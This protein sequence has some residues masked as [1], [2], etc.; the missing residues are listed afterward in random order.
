[1]KILHVHEIMDFA[2]YRTP[3]PVIYH[4]IDFHKTELGPLKNGNLTCL[5]SFYFSFWMHNACIR[6]FTQSDAGA[7]GEFALNAIVRLIFFWVVEV[8]VVALVLDQVLEHFLSHFLVVVVVEGV[9]EIVVSGG[10]QW[11]LS[12]LDILMWLGDHQVVSHMVQVVLRCGLHCSA[13]YLAL[14]VG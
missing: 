13:L 5:K 10:M 9:H 7:A 14:R 2:S 3:I 6:R 1:M 4:E 11:G 12:V 8:L